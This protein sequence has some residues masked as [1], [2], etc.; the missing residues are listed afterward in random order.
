[1]SKFEDQMQ[2]AK[3]R[4]IRNKMCNGSAECKAPHHMC[5]CLSQKGVRNADHLVQETDAGTMAS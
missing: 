5:I 1:M 4:A 3:E 2:E